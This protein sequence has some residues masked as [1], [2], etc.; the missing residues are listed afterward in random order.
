MGELRAE[1]EK[2][3][4]LA[5]FTPS[6]R[7]ADKDVVYYRERPQGLTIDWYIVLKGD[8]QVSVGCQYT[9]AGEARVRAAC[10]QVVRTMTVT[11]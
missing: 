10:E 3:Q 2:A 1:Y 4:N 8:A 5:D 11:G 6:T 7:F 9:P